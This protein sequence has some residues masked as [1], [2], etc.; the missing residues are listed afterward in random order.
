MYVEIAWLVLTAAVGQLR[1]FSNAIFLK[2]KLAELRPDVR[3]KIL[4]RRDILRL[5]AK[6]GLAAA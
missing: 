6:Y 1:T 3:V 2:R 5:D 4:Y